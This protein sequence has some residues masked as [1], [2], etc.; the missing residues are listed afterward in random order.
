MGAKAICSRRW[1]Q[2]L[3]YHVRLV[4]QGS[5]LSARQSRPATSRRSWVLLLPSTAMFIYYKLFV[6]TGSVS[7]LTSGGKKAKN[8][9]P[10]PTSTCIIPCQQKGTL[11]S[12]VKASSLSFCLPSI[13]KEVEIPSAL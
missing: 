1:T 2:E 9:T 3:A 10:I 4:I 6:P 11:G 5:V 8:L 13:E 7:V 12:V